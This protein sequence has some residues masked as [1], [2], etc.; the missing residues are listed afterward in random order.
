[1]QTAN[2]SRVVPATSGGSTENLSNVLNGVSELGCVYNNEVMSGYQNN[3]ALRFIGRPRGF[4][5][6]S[7]W[8]RRKSGITTLDDLK[9]KRGSP[10]RGRF[11]RQNWAYTFVEWADSSRGFHR[12]A[13]GQMKEPSPRSATTIRDR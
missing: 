13:A 7:L 6:C 5:H 10:R 8:S 3:N 11:R 1:M 9:G 12:G 2:W 4:P